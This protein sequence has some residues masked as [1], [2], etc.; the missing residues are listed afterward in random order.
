VSKFT[1]ADPMIATNCIIAALPATY[2]YSRF[3]NRELTPLTRPEPVKLASPLKASARLKLF[4]CLN[5]DSIS[6]RSERRR[7]HHL[8]VP[9]GTRATYA[10]TSPF[11]LLVH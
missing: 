2:R 1:Q 11:A 3:F 6:W 5:D 4:R 10:E 9:N 7:V 8:V